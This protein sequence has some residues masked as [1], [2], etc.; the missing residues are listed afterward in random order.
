M[1]EHSPGLA[2]R[3]RCLGHAA[4]AAIGALLAACSS[5]PAPAPAP[6]V[7]APSVASEAS[8]RQGEVPAAPAPGAV[9]RLRAIADGR[10]PVAEALDVVGGVAWVVLVEDASEGPYDPPTD[11]FAQKLGLGDEWQHARE[12]V[13]GEGLGPFLERLRGSLARRFELAG[14]DPTYLAPVCDDRGCDFPS[15]GEYGTHVRIDLDVT[16]RVEAVL[17]YTRDATIA[18][19]FQQGIDAWVF[20]T[21]DALLERRCPSG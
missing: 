4:P 19:E 12:L 15:P 21:R 2:E 10:V 5:T 8:Q 1:V 16:G 14:E 3:R 11:P 17:E 6:G 18:H 20:S 9:E 13:C 7:A